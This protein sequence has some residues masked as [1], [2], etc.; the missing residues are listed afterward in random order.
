MNFVKPASSVFGAPP[1]SLTSLR[2]A[3]KWPISYRSVSLLAI[4]CD[5]AIILICGVASGILYNL[6]AF[7]APGDLVRYFGSTAV[8]AALF[9]SLMKG[10]DLYSPA[11]LLA[12]R[13]QVFSVITAWVS[14]FLFL[15]GAAFALKVGDQFSRG[16]IFSFGTIGLGLLLMQRILFRKF[17]IRGLANQKFSGRNAIL[18]ADD[19]SGGSGELLHTLVKHGFQLEH[20][21]MLP[22]LPLNSNKLENF[23]SDVVEYVRGS[24]IEEIIVGV[25]ADRWGDLKTLLAGLRNLPLPVSLIPVGMASDVLSYPTHVMGDTI[26]IE[27]HRGPLGA[28]ERGVKRSI[29]VLSA[30]AGLLLFL[31][32]LTIV[33][34]LIKLDSPGPVLFRQRRCGFNGRP[35]RIFKFRTMSVLEDGPSVCQAAESDIRVTRLGKWLRRTSID[36]LP[37]LLNVLNGSMSLVGPRPHAIAHDNHFDKVVSNYAFRHHVKPGLTGWAQVNGHRGPTPTVAD[38]QRR[39]QFDLWYIDNWSLRLDML[40]IVKTIAEV[41]RSRNAY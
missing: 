11:E 14:V 16:A 3:R 30:I 29:D 39:V 19:A 18:I 5:V 26:C 7:G 23:I 15:F 24:D 36:E 25:D 28:F 31:P 37:Q 6:E 27:L 4:G 12:L 8:V 20:Q 13:T 41:M 32:L 35:F 38:I 34:V 10:R 1:E 17:L 2:P 33:A 21:F 22:A 40:I 9:I